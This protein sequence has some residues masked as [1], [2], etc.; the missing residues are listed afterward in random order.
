M[1]CVDAAPR[2]GGRAAGP[3]RKGP[4]V[5]LHG[6]YPRY[7]RIGLVLHRAAVDQERIDLRHG[8]R[9]DQEGP[10]AGEGLLQAA[11][12]IVQQVGDGPGQVHGRGVRQGQAA[13]QVAGKVLFRDVDARLPRLEGPGP[14]PRDDGPGRTDRQLDLLIEALIQLPVHF[15]ILCLKIPL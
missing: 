10:C 11:V 3:H 7:R 1:R 8:L 13:Q 9:Q 15:R 6:L 5:E 12:G 4:V 14:R 2:V